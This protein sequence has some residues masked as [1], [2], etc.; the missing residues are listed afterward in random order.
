MAISSANFSVRREE[1]VLVVESRETARP[2]QKIITM[3]SRISGLK[4]YA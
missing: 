4:P 3:W 1:S 2:L